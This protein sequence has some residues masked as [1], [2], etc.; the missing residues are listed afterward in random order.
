MNVLAKATF[1]LGF[2][3]TACCAQAQQALTPEA[4]AQTITDA[5]KLWKIV[6]RDSVGV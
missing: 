6:R 2:G 4:L 1:A 5:R 3:M